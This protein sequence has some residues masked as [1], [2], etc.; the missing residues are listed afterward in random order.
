MSSS[1]ER[2]FRL[3]PLEQR[4]EIVSTKME[5]WFS[6]ERDSNLKQV[7]LKFEM[8]KLGPQ[9]NYALMCKIILDLESFV[10]FDPILKIKLLFNFEQ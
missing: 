4:E 1:G 8:T 2:S 6:E 7:C 3:I 5:K 10:L 9:P